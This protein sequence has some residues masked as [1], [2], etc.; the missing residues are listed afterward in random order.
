MDYNFSSLI[1]SLNSQIA[2]AAKTNADFSAIGK[3]PDAYQKGFEQQKA[4]DLANAFSGG[5]PT[6]PDGSLDYDAMVQSLG[7]VGAIDKIVPLAN[8]GSIARLVGDYNSPSG[9]Q[10]VSPAVPP[11]TGS[12]NPLPAPQQPRL[13]QSD[14]ITPTQAQRVN[15]PLP[16]PQPAV[17]PPSGGVVPGQVGQ[18]NPTETIAQEGRMRAV[19]DRAHK[20]AQIAA[21]AGNV[22]LAKAYLA[23]FN[24]I[25]EQLSP[26]N[27]IK[28]YN[29]GR[30][31][32]ETLPDYEARMARE[33]AISGETGKAIGGQI[34]EYIDQ[35]RTAQKRIQQLDV[36]RDALERGNGN[37]TTGPFANLALKSK[38]AIGSLF[39][40]D[41][42]GTSEAEVI[43]K[44]GYG[45]ATQAVKEISQR[46][47]QL[48]F[49][50]GMENNPG[51][52]L[53]PKG[54]LMMMDILRQSARQDAQ[55]AKLLSR[56]ENHRNY[57]DVVDA[58]YNDPKNALVSPFDKSRK[59]GLKDLEVLK[60]QPQQATP[61]P[62]NDGWI[63]MPNGARV[64]EIKK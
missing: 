22:E 45:F 30:H 42:N 20:A 25:K 58:F 18:A 53:S 43:Q 7:R 56:P 51:L 62:D 49:I 38:Q 2:G 28:N 26:T 54:S 57:Q 36:M 41:V 9:S 19:M 55:L 21:A 47:S 16:Q 24:A 1:D 34:A 4:R 44:M 50:K 12:S 33:K 11:A 40:F 32:G 5:V 31:P 39:G 52:L 35:G 15:G 29:M 37:F 48:E 27:E 13:S 17:S 6:N 59:L 3:L 63:T 10:P 14:V 64:R 8:A 46:P 61:K 60:A 23:Q